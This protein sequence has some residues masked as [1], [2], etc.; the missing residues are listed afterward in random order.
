MEN[1]LKF[2]QESYLHIINT[3][4]THGYQ[5]GSFKEF[6]KNTKQEANNVM[7]LRHDVDISLECALELAEIEARLDVTATYFVMLTNDFYCAANK[8]S[9][10]IL[11]AIQNLGHE[12]GLHWD[13]RLLPQDNRNDFIEA[14]IAEKK[15]L[16]SLIQKPVTVASQHNPFV[17]PVVDISDL[18]Q[19]DAYSID[20]QNRYRYVS[21]S[22]MRWRQKTPLDLIAEG[23]SIQFN[24]HPVYW[25]GKGQTAD[26]KIRTAAHNYLRLVDGK[27]KD[28]LAIMNAALPTR[29]QADAQFRA[30]MG[31]KTR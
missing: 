9:R 12:I 17:S 4:K 11:N 21:D 29:D 24:S 23:C 3:A 16:E 20:I 1:K 28:F 25:V 14:F 30:K 13:S 5:V 26:E 31:W 7:L 27:Y 8:E 6:E 19:T 18:V 2:D 10:A 15:F 22:A